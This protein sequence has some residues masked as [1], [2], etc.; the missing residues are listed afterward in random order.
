MSPEAVPAR[1]PLICTCPAP[2]LDPALT[3]EEL[4]GSFGPMLDILQTALVG[5]RGDLYQAIDA[6][7]G[8]GGRGRSGIRGSKI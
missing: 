7:L 8:E 1:K 2:E 3:D 4:P 5:R 6:E